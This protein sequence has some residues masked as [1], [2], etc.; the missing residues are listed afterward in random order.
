MDWTEPAE[1]EF[2][3]IFEFT[4]GGW[5]CAEQLKW[6]G[7]R[8]VHIFT[9]ETGQGTPLL[10]PAWKWNEFWPKLDL[11]KV[12]NWDP[13]YPNGQVSVLTFDTTTNYSNLERLKKTVAGAERGFFR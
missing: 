2:P 10:I 9:L 6:D 12:W 8:M 11:A 13:D 7:W 3:E 5:G 4:F 1:P